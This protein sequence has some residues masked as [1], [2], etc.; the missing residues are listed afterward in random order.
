MGKFILIAFVLVAYATSAQ[1]VDGSVAVFNLTKNEFVVAADSLAG[2]ED[3]GVP[4]YFH[5]KI[6][7]FG[8]EFIFFVVGN[9]GWSN[10]RGGGFIQSWD[11]TELA[12]A[13]FH[14][15]PKPELDNIAIQWAND[16]KSHWDRLY[17]FSQQQAKNIAASNGGQ[18]T[19]G[20]FVTKRLATKVA[21]IRYNFN[22]PI[23]PIEVLLGD[24][25]NLTDCWVC[26]QL[27]GSKICAAG[28]HLDVVANFCASR[29]H[30]DKIEVRT[31]L[32]AASASTELP[33]KIVELTI[34]TYGKIAKDVGGA[35][36]AVTITK[37]GGITWNARKNNCPENQD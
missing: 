9:A 29:K 26:G 24:S 3:T 28:K 4:D 11:S 17:G 27:P 23:D 25:T 19:S 20:V 8:H 30:G 16:V 13:V 12:R 7:T 31:H 34:D 15:S 32:Q 35:V 6:A 37:S 5:C 10:S 22:R 36:D 18:F 2:N 33:V 21:I 1:V 14:G